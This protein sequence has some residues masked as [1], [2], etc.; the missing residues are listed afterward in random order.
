[1]AIKLPTPTLMGM[2][3]VIKRVQNNKEQIWGNDRKKNLVASN[4]ELK[5]PSLGGKKLPKLGQ[6]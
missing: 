6:V 5:L 3:H 2:L 1:V 4:G